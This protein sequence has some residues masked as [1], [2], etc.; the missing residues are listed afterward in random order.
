M[1]LRDDNLVIKAGP[2]TRQQALDYGIARFREREKTRR[3]L[4]LAVTALAIVSGIEMVF[5]PSG[6][7]VIAFIITPLLLVL[8]LGAIGVSRFVLKTPAAEISAG[9]SSDQTDPNAR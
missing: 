7:E 3:V 1:E 5:A 6:R 4:V 9:E 2:G 8:S